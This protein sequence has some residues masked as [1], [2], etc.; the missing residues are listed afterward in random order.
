[1]SIG[2]FLFGSG[3]ATRTPKIVAP[4]KPAEEPVAPPK[5]QEPQPAV[6]TPEPE[7]A[8]E[9]P[10][11]EPVPAPEVPAPRSTVPSPAQ[12]GKS[13]PRVVA[14]L[15][16]TEQARLLIESKR[17]DEAIS[18]LEKAMNIDANNGQNYYYLAEAWIIKGN[19]AQAVEFNRMAGLYLK[20]DEAWK[21]KVQQQ[22]GRIEKIKSAR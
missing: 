10:P 11:P 3:C 8:K 15:K 19:K 12:P 9:P 18:I 2:A 1:M 14:S 17:P 20:S 6:P 7:P 5:A 21:L 16:L 4:P 13:A 22:K